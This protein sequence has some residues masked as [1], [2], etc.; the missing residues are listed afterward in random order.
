MKKLNVEKTKYITGLILVKTGL[1]IG[2][3]GEHI[4]IGGLD[5]PVIRNPYTK[6]PY[7]PGSSLKGKMRS[8]TEWVDPN[9]E[10]NDE[11]HNCAV[12]ECKICRIFG[13]SAKGAKNG[14]TRLI[15]R[16]A[17]L[18]KYWKE[19][20][21]KN[22]PILE[23]K[24]EN[25]IKRISGTA[26]NPRQNQRVVPGVTFELDMVY[27][28]LDFEDSDK[29]WEIDENNFPMVINAMKLVQDT[30]LGGSGSRG[31]GQVEFV[32]VRVNGEILKDKEGNNIF[33]EISKEE[34]K[35]DSLSYLYAKN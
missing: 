29:P 34:L 30:Y 33:K 7:I 6:E 22:E 27:K 1:H 17:F 23:E 31:C 24:W 20:F 21:D 14:P 13:T 12:L 4:E 2:A 25:T 3:S 28:V 8:L 10:K 32:N 5:N 11:V 19:K 18:S 9:I 15:V 35:D 26:E 16:D